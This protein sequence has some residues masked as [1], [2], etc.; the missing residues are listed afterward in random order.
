VSRRILNLFSHV[1]I[2]VEVEDVCDEIEGILVVL[3]IRVEARKIEA[4]GKVVFIY[5]A[6]VFV[7]ARGDE[8]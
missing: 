5:L 4:V 2:A 6:V 8:L 1:V 3:Y 7:T